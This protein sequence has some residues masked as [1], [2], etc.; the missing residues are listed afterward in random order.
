MRCARAADGVAHRRRWRRIPGSIAVEHI[1][2]SGIYSSAMHSRVI[3]VALVCGL[4]CVACAAPAPSGATLIPRKAFFAEPD[5]TQLQLSPDGQWISYRAVSGNGSALWVAPVHEFSRARPAWAERRVLDYRWTYRPGQLLIAAA[6][7][8]G[9]GVH[10]FL[11]DVTSG[12]ARDVTPEPGLVVQI[13]QLSAGHPDDVLVRAKRPDGDSFDYDRLDLESGKRALVLADEQHFDRVLFDDDFR[14]RVAVRERPGAGYELLRPDGSR[15]WTPFASFAY[16]IEADSSQPIA[17]DRS[18]ATLYMVDNR[19]RN[20]AVL[21]AVD[22]A[23]GRESV[24]VEDPLADVLPALVIHPRTGRVQS[25]VSYYGR[26]R[27][28][29]LDGSILPDYEFLRSVHPGDIGFLAAGGRSLDD[30]TWLVT[31]MDGGPMRYYVYDRT[32]R[33]ASFL[34]SEDSALDQ[35]SLARRHLEVITTRDG[36]ELPADLYVPRYADDGSGRPRR[37]LPM[38]VYVHGG[39]WGIYPWN[40]WLTNRSLQLLADRGYAVLRVEFR[41]AGGFGRRIHDAGLREWGG[42]MQDDLADAVEWAIQHGIAARERIGIFGWSYG[43]YATL[44]ALATSTQFA[45]GL[46]M[47]A[48]TDLEAFVAQGPPEAK[49]AW[50][51]YIGDDTTDAGR[52]ALR[53]RSPLRNVER[54]DRPVI[55]AQGGKDEVVPRDQADTFVAAMAKHGKPVTYVLY[56]D[57]PH[58]LRRPESWTSLFAVAERFFHDHLGGLYEPLGDDVR[59][60]IEVRVGAARI[61]GLADALTRRASPPS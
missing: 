44:T 7:G 59:G 5:K 1:R 20:T 36:L 47:Y 61:P 39:S 6:P 29:F 17:V 42:K 41:G 13:E 55:V 9:D 8:V 4:V 16:G 28:H 10:L 37:P 31:F 46:A 15:A 26:Q 56:P 34:F 14:P 12:R 35:S 50:H 33:R 2:T 38:L 57:E 52:A 11:L 45:C 48:P 32:A 19:D 25:A 49:T 60:G 21:K 54:F 51:H 30:R 18:G 58:D 27:R 40:S 24:L 43:G 22:L 3:P 53:A 23:S